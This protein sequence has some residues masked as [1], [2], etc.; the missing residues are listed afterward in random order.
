MDFSPQDL[1]FAVDTETTG[2]NP[3]EHEVIEIGAVGFHLEGGIENRFEILIKPTGKQDP[4]ARAVH[5]ISNEELE[6]KGVDAKTALEKFS[7]FV[8]DSPLVFH[9][10]PFDISF[11]LIGLKNQGLPVLHNYYYDNFFLSRKYFKERKSHSLG[12]IKKSL[13]IETGQAHRA[14]SDAEATA[15][16][17]SAG[18]KEKLDSFSKTKLRDFLR[19]HR[20]IDEFQVK[21]PK[22]LA[23]IKRYF[24]GQ[25]RK[26][27]LI[28]LQYKDQKGREQ[29]QVVRP[30]EF[31]IF[32]QK[33]FIK[34]N[35]LING[36]EGLFPITDSIIHDPEKGRIKF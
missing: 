23:E 25:I 18:L 26:G 6:E 14:L 21:L 11:L 13:G 27:V 12:A 33:L 19:Y 28:K 32:N 5:N 34:G 9:N 15:L 4:R 20:R 8:G 36:E 7:A 10:A 35:S 31:M 17:F 24:D 1:W 30:L 29:T 2:L 22:N 16:I 3:W